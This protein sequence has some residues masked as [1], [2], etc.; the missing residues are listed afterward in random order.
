MNQKS[1]QCFESKCGKAKTLVENDMELGQ[2]HDY[3][4]FL[5][6]SMVDKM[7]EAQKQEQ[8]Y[9]EAQKNVEIVTEEAVCIE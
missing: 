7:V 8:A 5:K 9:A 3:L 1:M 2:F 6:G 4:M